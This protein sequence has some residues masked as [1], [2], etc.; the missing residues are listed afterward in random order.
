MLLAD[1]LILI[2]EMCRWYTARKVHMN[3]MSK[4]HIIFIFVLF[5][6]CGHD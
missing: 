4:T 1:S 6:L 3:A 2:S 5:I